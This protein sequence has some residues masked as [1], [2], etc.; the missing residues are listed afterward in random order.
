MERCNSLAQFPRYRISENHA[1]VEARLD[2]EIDDLLS[3]H[4]TDPE[5][6]DDSE[7]EVNGLLADL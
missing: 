7:D 2:E 5:N 6:S 1:A 4:L 3:G